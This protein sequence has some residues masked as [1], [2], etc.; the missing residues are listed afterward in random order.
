MAGARAPLSKQG[1]TWGQ[2]RWA[3]GWLHLKR[4]PKALQV[5]LLAA[6]VVAGSELSS[7]Y[8]LYRHYAGLHR[9]FS[10]DGSAAVMLVLGL[11]AR[12]DGRREQFDLSIDHGP[13]FR[14]DPIFGYA[15]YPGAYHITEA[16]GGQS[17]RFN[18][19]VDAL[20]HRVTSYQPILRPRRMF[21]TGDSSMFGWGLDDEQTIPWLLQTRF[22]G[23]EVVNLSL[24][25]YSTI[26]A[27]LQLDRASPAVAADDLVVLTYHPIT[28]DFNVASSTM[29]YY[30]KSGF[31]R[32]L[33]D[34]D[35]MRDMALPFGS[36][37]ARNSLGV[38]YYAMSCSLRVSDRAGCNHP[39]VGPR[40]A[41]AVTQ[42]AFDLLMAAHPAHYVVA[43]LSGV[44]SDPV[45][46]HLRSEG[47]AIADLRTASGDPDATDEVF[48]D[49][50]AGPFW[51]HNTAERLADALR[52]A[53]FVD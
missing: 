51:H 48:S 10:P 47:V 29:I 41:G 32:R 4:R 2:W 14:S 17:H 23:F 42:R 34:A 6:V 52:S 36:I 38:G 44:D 13:L 40:E 7:S 49:G 39:E 28:N 35:L 9:S 20:G 50:H 11:K 37:D 16:G 12:L 53:H 8:F 45:I 19:T 43:F 30:L 1:S 24:N 31:E 25:S 26:H 33:G 46:A 3:T 21:F 18:L 5:V 27:R 15:M 22:P